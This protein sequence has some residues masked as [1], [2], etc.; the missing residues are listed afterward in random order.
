MHPG[1]SATI[2]DIELCIWGHA[3][4]APSV[5]LSKNEAFTKLRKGINGQLYFAH[6]DYSAYSIFEEAFDQGYTAANLVLKTV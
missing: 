4:I 5:G 2:E 3:M 6:S 1:I